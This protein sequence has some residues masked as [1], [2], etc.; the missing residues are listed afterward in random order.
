MPSTTLDELLDT[1]YLNLGESSVLE[2]EQLENL[3]SLLTRLVE[4]SLEASE[5]K[6]KT[7]LSL[8]RLGHPKKD[9]PA[10]AQI[11]Q[12]LDDL[13]AFRDDSHIAS[14]SSLGVKPEAWEAFTYVWRGEANS[15]EELAEKLTFRVYGQDDYEKALNDLV[16]LGWLESRAQGF[17][18]TSQGQEV[19]QQAEDQT[20]RAF[21]G[22]WSCLSWPEK[23]HL[24]YLLARLKAGAEEAVAEEKEEVP[25]N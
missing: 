20:N 5:P 9:Y 22:P 11:D 7:V 1:F 14:W 13:N 2:D 8:T 3:A 19:R 24:R 15:A 10:L 6:E 16:A 4:G 18:V 21:F 17:E 25:A 12:R 23:N